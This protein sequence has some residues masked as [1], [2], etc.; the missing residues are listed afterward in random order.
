MIERDHPKLAIA[1][2]CG[3]LLISRAGY[4]HQPKSESS[5]NLELM[6]EIDRQFL[7]T[8]F[9]GVSRRWPGIYKPKAAAAKP[10]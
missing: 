3:L 9:Y 4:Y 2:Q 7:D 5:E 1:K 8:S 6:A 10:V